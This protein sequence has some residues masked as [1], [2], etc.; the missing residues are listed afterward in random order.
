MNVD[1]SIMAIHHCS[2][3]MPHQNMVT[4]ASSIERNLTHDGICISVVSNSMLIRD[5]LLGMLAPHMNSCRS[6]VGPLTSVRGHQP[7]C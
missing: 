1:E 6:V 4:S 2:D 5:G 3:D 7:K